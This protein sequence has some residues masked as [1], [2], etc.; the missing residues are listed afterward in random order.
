MNCKLIVSS[1]YYYSC[2]I[3]APF[4]Q[5]VPWN[6]IADILRRASWNSS[7]D[8]VWQ[9]IAFQ[10]LYSFKCLFSSSQTLVQS[11]VR[12]LVVDVGEQIELSCETNNSISVSWNHFKPGAKN[13]KKITTGA[14]VSL[15][16]NNTIGL[17]SLIINQAQLSEGGQYQCVESSRIIVTYELAVLGKFT[18]LLTTSCPRQNVI[19]IQLFR[20]QA[21]IHSQ[22]FIFE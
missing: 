19:D 14:N 4:D 1:E 9:C 5:Q 17:S 20:F 11:P 16:I 7:W 18:C 2:H 15:E 21:L 22:D 6:L 3:A 10:H 12:N 13:S 8:S